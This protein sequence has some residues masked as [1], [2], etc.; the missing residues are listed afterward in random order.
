MAKVQFDDTEPL[1]LGTLQFLYKTLLN[2]DECVPRFGSH[3][4]VSDP[5]AQYLKVFDEGQV[6][7]AENT[8]PQSNQTLTDVNVP[9]RGLCACR[10]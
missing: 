5:H 1:H 2:V 3:W 4:E 7:H 8:N 9:S 6:E 10:R